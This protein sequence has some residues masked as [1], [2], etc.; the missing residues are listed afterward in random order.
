MTS[1]KKNSLKKIFTRKNGFVLAF[2]LPAII[3]WAIIYAYPLIQIF[4]TSFS[5]W[6]YKN[7]LNPEF[8]GWEN[9]FDTYI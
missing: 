7:F 3:L 5:K 4:F 2:L 1:P 8:L 9:M 6:N